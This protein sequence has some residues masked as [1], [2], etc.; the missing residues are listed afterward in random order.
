MH[1]FLYYVPDAR[2]KRYIPANAG[3]YTLPD[4]DVGY[5]YGLADSGI[6]EEQLI[7][8]FGKDVVLLLGREDVNR[9]D[10]DLRKTPEADEQGPNRFVRG[11]TMFARAKETADALGVELQWRLKIVDGASHSN[12]QMAQAAA[13]FV[14]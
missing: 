12:A 10:P 3:W 13:N 2:V 4:F 7:E 8:A 1:R 14:K 5:P 9:S 6:T 11:Q